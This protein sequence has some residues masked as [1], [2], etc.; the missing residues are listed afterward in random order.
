MKKC[1]LFLI[2]AALSMLLVAVPAMAAPLGIYDAGPAGG[3]PADLDPVLQGWEG[4]EVLLGDN[5]FALQPD[6][7]TGY[8]AWQINDIYGTGNANS[9]L[10]GPFH[11][12]M[13]GAAEFKSMYD[14]G[15]EFEVRSRCTATS[16]FAG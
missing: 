14:N 15:W 12:I 11:R 3:G 16:S 10:D 9:A 6:G 8:N 5:V 2:F 4:Y 1:I 7:T 13:L